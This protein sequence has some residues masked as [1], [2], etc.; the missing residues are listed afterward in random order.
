MVV[1]ASDNGFSLW[2]NSCAVIHV[3]QTVCLRSS[4]DVISSSLFSFSLCFSSCCISFILFLLYNCLLSIVHLLGIV[5]IL[6]LILGISLA[7]S[8][9]GFSWRL[10]MRL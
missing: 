3:D 5:F 6:L 2:V 1:D 7:I 8:R 10:N 9:Y 4:L